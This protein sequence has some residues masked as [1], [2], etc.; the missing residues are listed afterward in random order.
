MSKR[1]TGNSCRVQPQAGVRRVATTTVLAALVL[2]LASL[3]APRWSCADVTELAA[4]TSASE[5]LKGAGAL[6]NANQHAA[7]GQQNPAVTTVFPPLPYAF[8]GVI[9]EGDGPQSAVL[10]RA[11]ETLVVTAGDVLDDTYRVDAVRDK[12]IDLTYLPSNQK[13]TMVLAGLSSTAPVMV[14]P[15]G[16]GSGGGARN[17]A[18]QPP[19]NMPATRVTAVNND[20]AGKPMPPPVPT[21]LRSEGGRSGTADSG[22]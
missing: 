15:Q 11:E 20:A 13:N 7:T 6:P 18:G 21:V 10:A 9:S 3:V 14:G 16:N 5:P 19:P 8:V 17:P 4:S 1:A 2:V 22:N 12:E